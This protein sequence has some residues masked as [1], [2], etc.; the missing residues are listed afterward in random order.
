MTTID[1]ILIRH[2]I[3][4]Y[5]KTAGCRHDPALFN[6]MRL[7]LGRLEGGI[8]WAQWAQP[9]GAQPK[10]TGARPP[11]S[12]MARMLSRDDLRYLISVLDQQV[13]KW[14]LDQE[15]GRRA[16]A[17]GDILTHLLINFPSPDGK[18][19]KRS[20]PALEHKKKER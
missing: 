15:Q 10:P 9:K 18:K 1:Q 7:V 4:V 13:G 11:S 17:V 2:S 5:L 19:C 14:G 20:K 6:D 3:L 8:D 12:K 16:Q